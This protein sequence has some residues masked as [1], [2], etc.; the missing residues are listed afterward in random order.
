[1]QRLTHKAIGETRTQVEDP[2]C[3]FLDSF[4]YRT[5]RPAPRNTLIEDETSH[6]ADIFRINKDRI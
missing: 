6:V 2:I 3:R 1:M 4:H 5:T